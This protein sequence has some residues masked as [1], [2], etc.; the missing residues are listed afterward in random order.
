MRYH[1]E[2]SCELNI[3]ICEGEMAGLERLADLGENIEDK[4]DKLYRSEILF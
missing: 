4:L 1:E 3:I 2:Q